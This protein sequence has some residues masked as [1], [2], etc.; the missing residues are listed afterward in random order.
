MAV[1]GHLEQVFGHAMAALQQG[2]LDVAERQFKSLLAAQP[3]H[4]G[5]LNLLGV[6][7]LRL[8]KAEDAER[9]L[10]KAL[11]SGS[12]PATLCNYAMALRQ[13]GRGADALARLDQALVLQP[14]SFDAWNSRGLVLNDLGC[15]ADAVAGFEKA[16]AIRPDVASAHYNLGNSLALLKRYDSALAACER[17]LAL[18]AGFALAQ[19]GRSQ[20]LKAR[21]PPPRR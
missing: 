6:V 17:A 16:V 5:A 4:L 21:R 3:N 19:Y 20:M 10:R 7:Q 18:S 11:R 1:P 14:D 13:L 9:V 12:D 8:G 2:A 15:Y